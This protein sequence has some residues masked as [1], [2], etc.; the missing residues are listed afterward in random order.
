M[1]LRERFKMSRIRAGCSKIKFMGMLRKSG[2]GVGVFT[3]I[4]R[5]NP[6]FYQRNRARQARLGAQFREEV[7]NLDRWEIRKRLLD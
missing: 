2:V 6:N 5:V 3:D 7:I 4:R 1:T